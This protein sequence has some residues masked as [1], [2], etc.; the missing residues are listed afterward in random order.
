MRSY[1]RK[2]L[3]NTERYYNEK[4]FIVSSVSFFLNPHFIIRGYL[5]WEL[6][7]SV[8]N[9]YGKVLDFGCGNMPYKSLFTYDE[10]IGVDYETGQKNAGII[11]IRDSVLPFEN[12]TFDSIIATEVLEHVPDIEKT[13][14][15]LCR[16]L[17]TGGKIIVSV[18]FAWIEHA[19]P[20][21]FRRW[22][23]SGI[24]KDLNRKG[25]RVLQV[26][27]TTSVVLTI[28][29]LWAEIIRRKLFIYR[30]YNILTIMCNI[31]FHLILIVPLFITGYIVN[32]F[33][34]DRNKIF[35]LNLMVIAEK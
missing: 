16:V 25:F 31:L 11:Y 21:D 33:V 19:H 7:R 30:Y 23:E 17:K 32:L 24:V 2:I 22:T 26:K 29:Q 4:Q 15:E 13:L 6:K 18:P 14:T 34:T 27:K 20:Y 9:I 10:Y 28:T 1:I 12:N 5:F 35:P 8:K 3:I